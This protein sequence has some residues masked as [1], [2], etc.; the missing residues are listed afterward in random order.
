MPHPH[1]H[2]RSLFPSFS[3]SIA[4]VLF[5]PIVIFFTPF[6][7]DVV[8]WWFVYHLHIGITNTR[9]CHELSAIDHLASE[10]SADVFV[11]SPYEY[12]ER[13]K[14]REGELMINE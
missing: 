11:I 2:P 4:F 10:T 1:T 7:I 13:E 6:E 3:L 5:R 14:E 12:R 8:G 9:P